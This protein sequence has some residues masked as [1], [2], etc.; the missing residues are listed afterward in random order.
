M[1]G[2]SRLTLP[3]S[4]QLPKSFELN[5]GGTKVWAHGNATRH[6]AE[7]LSGMASGGATREQVDLTTQAQLSSLQSTVAEAGSNGLPLAVLSIPEGGN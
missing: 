5:S 4:R 7:Y 6:M 3:S 2:T 1:T